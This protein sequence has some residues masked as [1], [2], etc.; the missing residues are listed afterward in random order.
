MELLSTNRYPSTKLTH[1]KS[2][3]EWVDALECADF[4]KIATGYISLESIIELKR[5]IE[6]NSRPK[7]DLLIGM[8][9]FERFTERQYNA[10]C[11]LDSL[12]HSRHLGKVYLADKTKYHGKMYAF[13][14][15][16]SCFCGIV[17]SSNL[18]SFCDPSSKLFEIDC[19]FRDEHEVQAI[20]ETVTRIIDELGSPLS[21]LSVKEFNEEKNTL[22]V[23]HQGVTLI[24][25]ERLQELNKERTQVCFEIPIKT[26]PKSHLNACFGKGRENKNNNFVMPRSWY[27]VELILPK[28]ITS[29]PNFP[30]NQEIVVCTD[31]GWSFKCKSQGDYGKNFRS[32][33]DLK[34]LGKWIKGKLEFAGALEI[35]KPV[36]NEVL[37]KY[38]KS[39]ITLEQTS[40][41]RTWLI[42]Y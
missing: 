21:D 31:D 11:E 23:N 12:L 40:C 17:G 38:G 2:K 26:C 10:V 8:H 1:K 34:I 3:D 25:K 32:T 14:K 41:S 36:T 35:G 24:S 6:L 27:E 20:D 13:L 7:V 15:N 4:V 9:F 18:S 30:K 19:L 16:E 42:S 22:L 33:D 28:S 37:T 39:V 29:L 5:I